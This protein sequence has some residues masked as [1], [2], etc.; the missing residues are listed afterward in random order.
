V[1]HHKAM[2]G[3]AE[4]SYTAT[5]AEYVIKA[6]DGT[7]KASF[8]FVAYTKDNVAD[9]MPAALPC[10]RQSRLLSGCHRHG[11]CRWVLPKFVK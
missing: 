2:I 11:L 8:F 10:G 3:G 6:D 1:T 9:G 7:P 4:I 5:A